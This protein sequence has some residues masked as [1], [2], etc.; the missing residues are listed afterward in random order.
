[1]LVGDHDILRQ[2]LK[3]STIKVM[4][5]LNIHDTVSKVRRA[6]AKGIIESSLPEV[7][8]G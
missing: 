3:A 8:H 4:N 7:P 5:K 6:V 1:L 2:G